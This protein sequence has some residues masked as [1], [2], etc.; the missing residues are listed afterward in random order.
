MPV[1]NYDC[2][3]CGHEM[4][5][6]LPITSK[7]QKKLDC[8]ECEGKETMIRVLSKVNFVIR[9][10]NAKNGYQREATNEE[11][12]M[13]SLRTLQ[14]KMEDPYY[15]E[16][17]SS[18][19]G[20]S[21]EEKELVD[22]ERKAKKSAA[23]EADK[24]YRYLKDKYREVAGSLEKAAKKVKEKH[25]DPNYARKS[26]KERGVKSDVTVEVKQSEIKLDGIIEE[27]K[28]ARKKPKRKKLPV[29]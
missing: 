17:L 25:K 18:P 13:P 14:K 6:I 3:A 12:G 24:R 11:L 15:I 10:M 28:G 1:Y 29:P 16:N 20:L 7:R 23:E 21:A 4:E 22:D 2:D 27:P 5:I 8:P 26:A 19:T 9:G